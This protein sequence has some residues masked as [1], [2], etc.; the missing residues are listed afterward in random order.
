MIYI[1][2]RAAICYANRRDGKFVLRLWFGKD[3]LSTSVVP[4]LGWES[5]VSTFVSEQQ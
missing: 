2:L 1:G 5:K 4:K 3:L